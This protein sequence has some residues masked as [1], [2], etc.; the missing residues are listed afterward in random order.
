MGFKPIVPMQVVRVRKRGARRY[1]EEPRPILDSYVFCYAFRDRDVQRIAEIR[2]VIGH[3]LM[4]FQDEKD[5]E[6]FAREARAG[7]FDHDKPGG[8][9]KPG[10]VM[11]LIGGM[12]EG[13]LFSFE[14]MRRERM[15]GR[16]PSG[17]RVEVD[18]DK[19]EVA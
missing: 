16:L 13:L 3:F 6:R 8:N 9:L 15:V 5:M 14:R 17:A 11:R 2:D 10:Q 7:Y 4:S 18:R 19:A 1:I 12:F